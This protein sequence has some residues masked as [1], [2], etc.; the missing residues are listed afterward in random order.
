MNRK[1]SLP[2]CLVRPAII[3]TSYCEPFPGW[4]DS[5]A[6]AAALFLFVGLGIVRYALVDVKKIGDCI[7]VDT[8][9]SAIIVATA[10]NIHQQQRMPIVQVGTSDLNPLTWA[11]M[12]EE[13]QG[14]WN[15]TV[16]ASKMSKCLIY[17]STRDSEVNFHRLKHKIPI[18]VY[19][20]ISPLMGKQ[21]EKNANKMLKTFNRGEEVS[22]LF[23][24]FMNNEWIY[25]GKNIKK[26]VNWLNPEERKIFP[27][28][29]S[30]ID[31]RKFIRINNYGI[32]KYILKE[33]AEEP[34]KSN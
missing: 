3:N 13:I 20:R 9:S 7:P 33:H 34:I 32:Q 30:E 25:E 1:G 15:S 17:T 26:L 2:L 22:K 4:I 18:Q 29:I 19:K 8:V 6:A 16:S 10:F 12:R 23:R 21:H 27:I 11:E 5:L 28:D 14:Y 31:G 24:F